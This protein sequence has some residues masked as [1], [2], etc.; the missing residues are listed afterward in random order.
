MACYIYTGKGCKSAEQ[1]VPTLHSLFHASPI[2]VG[3][4]NLKSISTEEWLFWCSF[5][6]K[7]PS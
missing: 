3:F 4:T 2:P 1:E 5:I 7:Y 6:L